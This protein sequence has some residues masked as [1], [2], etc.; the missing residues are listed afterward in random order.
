MRR[1][2][3]HSA[4]LLCLVLGV[5]SGCSDGSDDSQSGG[6]GQILFITDLHFDPYSE[7]SA[8]PRLDAQ[9]HEE[10]K[11]VFLDTPLN[12]GAYG[13]GTTPWMF[14]SIL[15]QL[16][17]KASRADFVVFLGDTLAH[18]F[19]QSYFTLS[20]S[21]D[22]AR[23]QAFTLKTYRFFYES[24]AEALPGKTIVFALGNNDY[25]CGDYQIQPSGP[26][27]ADLSGLASSHLNLSA[28]DRAAF[29]QTFPRGGYYA[30]DFPAHP[31]LRLIVL[32]AVFFSAYY[33][34]RCGS[35][36]DTSPGQEELEWLHSQLEDARQSGRLVW[37][38]L[39][40]PPGLN[41]F[42]TINDHL[43][44]GRIEEVDDFWRE[45][46]GS[47]IRILMRE[48]S[49]VLAAS[50]SG[51]THQDDFR[52]AADSP[53]FDKIVPALSPVFANNPGFVL[54]SYDSADPYKLDY[55]T[56]YMDLTANRHSPFHRETWLAEYGYQSTYQVGELGYDSLS[57]LHQLTYE[58]ADIRRTF[59]GFYDVSNAANEPMSD[60]DHFQ[61]Y[62]CGQS[63]WSAAEFLGCYNS[64]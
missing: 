58:Q 12:W 27:L 59:E 25:Y 48:Y 1:I 38:M 3:Y 31:H 9:G 30:M 50:F 32:N 15:D 29:D 62:W 20:A 57:L 53:V 28:E 11:G 63:F 64:R 16:K 49:D 46:F 40:I 54:V 22:R 39:H 2:T 45:E 23:M 4:V 56:F 51:H 7:P 55:R 41:I 61:A 5:F 43:V 6:S 52:A 26:L 44:D 35:E 60:P 37:L 17:A 19:D 14:F 47:G 18:N 10:W 8:F 33:S 21:Q 24:L 13:K 34:N 36:P 42:G